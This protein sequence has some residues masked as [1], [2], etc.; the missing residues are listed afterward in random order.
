MV[1]CKPLYGLLMSNVHHIEQ[2][3]RVIL[4]CG[5]AFVHLW[6]GSG[7]YSIL[8]R[9]ALQL[10]SGGLVPRDLGMCHPLPLCCSTS[11]KIQALE[12]KLQQMQGRGHSSIS[13]VFKARPPK[14]VT[15]RSLALTRGRPYDLKQRN[16][17]PPL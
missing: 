4:F 7:R 1:H 11:A 12:A 9:S 3:E 17:H 15:K 14:T 8:C 5:L 13:P 2:L 16:T 6:D 10:F